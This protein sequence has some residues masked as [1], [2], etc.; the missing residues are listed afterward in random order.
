MERSKPGAS[1]VP[2]ETSVVTSWSRIA[3]DEADESG[4]AER[5]DRRLRRSVPQHVMAHTPP[6]PASQEFKSCQP[7]RPSRCGRAPWSGGK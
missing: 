1:S 6:S 7:V 3:H 2:A 4:L 5:Q